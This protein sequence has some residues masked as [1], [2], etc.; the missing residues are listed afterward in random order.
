MRTRQSRGHIAGFP[1]LS[2][3]THSSVATGGRQSA[4]PPG[5]QARVSPPPPAAHRPRG[6]ARRRDVRGAPP[7]GDLHTSTADAPSDTQHVPRH[8]LA[9]PCTRSPPGCVRCAE[10]DSGGSRDSAQRLQSSQLVSGARE[11]PVP[12][13]ETKDANPSV[14]FT[15]RV[16]MTR[17]LGDWR[18]EG[19]GWRVGSA[20][21][22]K[23]GRWPSATPSLPTRV[24]PT[25]HS[26]PRAGTVT[27]SPGPSKRTTR[28]PGNTA[29]PSSILPWPFSAF[30]WAAALPC[31]WVCRLRGGTVSQRPLCR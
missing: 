7:D 25:R 5:G 9:R 3:H 13:V 28:S 26:A 31:A 10:E 8:C 20:F 19:H 6:P 4:L 24:L 17:E 2:V 14:G 1:G 21:P 15:Q 30:I 11:C 22:G 16:M 23:Q 29:C 18:W 12:T 27:R